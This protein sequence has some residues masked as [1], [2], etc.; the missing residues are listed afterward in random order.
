MLLYKKH[1]EKIPKTW[2]IL[3]Q[4]P[5]V[6]TVQV[7]MLK[8]GARVRAHFGDCS[9]IVRSH[10]GV[11]IPGT[12]PELGIR[13]GGIAKCWEQG[14]VM[15][16]CDAHRHYVWNNTDQNRIVLLIDTIH[17]MFKDRKFYICAGLLAAGVLK[18]ILIMMPFTKRAPTWLIHLTHKIGIA[19][20][21]PL[22]LIQ[23]VFNLGYGDIFNKIKYRLA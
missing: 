11:S 10:L 12:L 14:K 2:E 4:I 20:I 21:I 17:P 16:F 6:V 22:L 7:S 23:K 3:K 13:I 5:D 19:I 9:G 1:A 15:V 18:I 8:P